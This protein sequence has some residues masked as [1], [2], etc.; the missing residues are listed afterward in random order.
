M[1]NRDTI[2]R[3]TGREITKRDGQEKGNTEKCYRAEHDEMS[4][5]DVTEMD[6]RRSNTEKYYRAEHD[7]MSRRDVTEM[8]RKK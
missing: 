8:D 6:R 7:E 5:R 2:Q 3:W 4:R 1:T